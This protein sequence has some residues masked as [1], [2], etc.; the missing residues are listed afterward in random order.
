MARI[1]AAVKPTKSSTYC[2]RKSNFP[3]DFNPTNSN[4]VFFKDGYKYFIKTLLKISR[5]FFFSKCANI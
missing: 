1:N 4:Q 2:R 3:D 5:Q